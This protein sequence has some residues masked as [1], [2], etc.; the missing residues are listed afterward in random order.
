MLVLTLSVLGLAVVDSINPSVLGVTLFLLLKRQTGRSATIQVLTYL[1]AVA[2]TYFT[3][4]VLLMLGLSALSGQ[5]GN[6][7]QSPVTYAITGV[8]GVALFAWSWV[9]HRRDKKNPERHR[10]RKPRLPISDRLPALFALG[11]LVSIL[12]FSTALPFLAAVALMT[13]NGLSAAVWLPLLAVYVLIM[14]LPELV[15]LA[16]FRLLSESR[17]ARL[18]RLR[19]KM[20]ANT[21]KT[22]QWIAAIVGFLLI[23]NAVGYFAIALGWYTPKS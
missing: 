5:L 8:L 7:L 9:D 3:L 18:E 15:L 23:R 16:V 19:D 14:V 11:L 4:G 12:E 1:A 17:R 6:L 21:R 13:T 10:D 20:S 2:A 22:V